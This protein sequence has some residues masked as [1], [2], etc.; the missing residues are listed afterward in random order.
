MTDESTP[1]ILVVDSSKRERY[2]SALDHLDEGMKY[3]RRWGH[4]ISSL[5]QDI[6]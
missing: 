3:I 1:L 5:T 4:G 6:P 2:Q